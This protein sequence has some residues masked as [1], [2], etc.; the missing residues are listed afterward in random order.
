MRAPIWTTALL[1][2]AAACA[3]TPGAL[4]AQS[5]GAPAAATA[6]APPHGYSDAARRHADCVATYPGYD[7]RTDTYEVRPGVTR[8]CPL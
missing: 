4:E 8:R 7:P 1:C 6:Q 5:Y 2:A 3:E